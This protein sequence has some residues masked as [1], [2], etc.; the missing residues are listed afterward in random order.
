MTQ[1]AL[2][3]SV[4]PGSPAEEAGYRAGMILEEFQGSPLRDV[5]DWMWH[6]EGSLQGITFADPLFDGLRTCVNACTFCFMDMLPPGMRPALS[7][8]DDDYR[9]SF[10]QGNFVTLTNMSTAEVERVIEQRLSPLRVSLHAVTPAVRE[11]L[12]GRTHARGLEALEQLLA[13][14]IKVHAQLVLM[15]DVND[16]EELEAS[17]AFCAARPNILSVGIVPYGYTR[18]AR[19]QQGYDGGR[20]RRV[21]SQ[22]LFRSPT[23]QLA[24]AFFLLAG[25]PLPPASYYGDYLQYENGIGMVRSFMDDADAMDTVGATDATSAFGDPVCGAPGRGAPGRS[26]TDRSATDRGATDGTNAANESSKGA[27]LVTGEAFAPILREHTG[28]RVIAIANRFFGG[29][30]DVAGLLTAQDLIEQLPGQLR[31]EDRRVVLPRTMFNDD[32]LTLD[33][34]SAADLAEALKRQ[35]DVVP[36]SSQELSE[37]RNPFPVLPVFGQQDLSHRSLS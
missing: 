23:V 31:T 25:L 10:L 17:L 14:G 35:V 27:V 3:A 15:P 5:L 12:M 33:N 32:G 8:R 16:G 20:A 26:T 22:C 29:N 30:V 1:G 13:A 7:V 34:R 21:V 9:L 37:Q 2:I 36:C 19:I 4:E 24:D 18:Y 28:L 6:T 11:H